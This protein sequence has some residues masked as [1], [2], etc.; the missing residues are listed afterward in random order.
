MPLRDLLEDFLWWIAGKS[1]PSGVCPYVCMSACLYVCP[2]IFGS[3]GETASQIGT[4]EHSFDAPER[5]NDDVNGFGPFGCTRH[6]PCAIAQILAK[7][8]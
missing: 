2:S 5:Q 6:V 8:L 1:R 3:G 7:K 4:D